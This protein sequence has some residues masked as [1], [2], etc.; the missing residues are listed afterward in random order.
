MFPSV[1]G[2]HDF[3]SPTF[4]AGAASGHQRVSGLAQP[5]Y[6]D[7]TKGAAAGALPAAATGG[8]SEAAL[9]PQRTIKLLPVCFCSSGCFCC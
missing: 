3:E 7:I 2:L 6:C 5:L 1:G 4:R 9:G 8:A